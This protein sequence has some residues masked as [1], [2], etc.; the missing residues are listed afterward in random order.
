M[1]A[2]EQ[3]L[4]QLAA[5]LDVTAL[6][7]LG[8]RGLLRR[9]QKDLERGV[10]IRVARVTD[11]TL[12]LQLGE[13]EVT[14]PAAGPAAATCSCPAGGVCQH[15]LGALLHLRGEASA[16][17]EVVAS[18]SV[19]QQLMD[20]S[21]EQ[22]EEWAGTSRFNAG[23]KQARQSAVEIIREPTTRIRLAG[24]NADVHFV[25]NAGLDGMIVSGGR[26]D[27]HQSVV[28]AVIAFQRADGRAGSIAAAVST[29]E[30]SDGA[31]RTREEI[32]ASCELLLEETLS[33]GLSR[34][35][36]SNQQRWATLA[37]S[38]L[39]VN[40]PRLALRLRDMGDE[41]ALVMSRDARSD[42]ARMLAKMGEM[43]ALCA[44]LRVG[45]D[46]RSDL[47]GLHRTRY[48]EV[49]NLELL[50]AAAWPW[51]TQSGHEGL[52]TLFWEPSRARW[53]SWTESRPSH[54]SADFKPMARYGQPG[55]WEGAESPRRLVRST[56]RLMN[57]RQNPNHRLSGSAKSR[58]LV[59][60][61]SALLER[62]PAAVDDWTELARLSAVSVQIGLM[63]SN[64]LDAIFA[65]K[66]TEWGERGFDVVKQVFR[67]RLLDTAQRTLMLEVAFD[68]YTQTVIQYLENASAD[69]VDGALIIGRVQHTSR[70]LSLH[71]F[72]IHPQS[73]DAVQL[74]FGS[75]KLVAVTDIDSSATDEL[76][77]E[78]EEDVE[79][80][81]VTSSAVGRV[82]DELDD[83]LLALA[84]AGLAMPN[85]LRVE[86]MREIES[87][88]SRL[89]LHALAASAN[90]V[91]ARPNVR[92]LLRCTYMGQL[93]RRAAP[94]AVRDPA[95][96]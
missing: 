6:E 25:P 28:A 40:L 46:P 20:I 30:A 41:V 49:G 72:A 3:R 75:Q 74:Y 65:V 36:T 88:A 7:A 11:T 94:M 73:G 26:N 78:V 17:V 22:L 60:G 52:T 16:D 51:K 10:E 27:E 80:A 45:D 71:P 38:A 5:S 43:H 77:F 69:S 58:A 82:L 67:W 63:E 2:L 83:A 66:P 81:V 91:V 59:T 79:A 85:P 50:G 15:I 21:P 32:L 23:V 39:G 29:L 31:P 48:D 68:A 35:S 84:E 62:G 37:V 42:L 19:R 4:R 56:F 96:A 14:I 92:S 89:G 64:P 87:R 54:Q 70:G 76:T 1:S 61:P 13:Y 34:L 33:N 24:L 9:A 55:P 47:V 95:M 18:E 12:H 8:S 57:A 90:N 44:A 93:H 53:S 86:R